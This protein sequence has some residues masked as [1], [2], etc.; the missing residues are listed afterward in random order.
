MRE[1]VFYLWLSTKAFEDE[2]YACLHFFLIDITLISFTF[3][4]ATD[5]L[6]CSLADCAQKA[7]LENA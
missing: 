6:P 1:I 4:E 7:P 3:R 5:F 2:S